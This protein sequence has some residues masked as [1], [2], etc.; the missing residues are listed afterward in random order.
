MKTNHDCPK[1]FSYNLY[2]KQHRTALENCTPMEY[3]ESRTYPK[4]VHIVS[5]K[6]HKTPQTLSGLKYFSVLVYIP[7]VG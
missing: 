7:V 4:T 2:K 6:I 3:I 1:P 5:Y